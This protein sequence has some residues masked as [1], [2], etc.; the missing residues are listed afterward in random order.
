M[1]NTLEM[2]PLIVVRVP[3][4]HLD[5]GFDRFWNNNDPVATHMFNALSFLFP[6]GERYFINAAKAVRNSI[7]FD[8]AKLEE[9]IKK[10]IAQESVHTAQHQIYNQILEFQGYKNI[11]NTHLDWMEH[12]LN[13]HFSPLF[14]L[15]IVVAFEHYTAILGDWILNSPQPLE[16]ANKKMALIWGWHAIEEVEHK[17]VCFDLYEKAGGGYFMRIWAFLIVSVNFWILHMRNYQYALR[18]DGYLSFGNILKTIWKT[19]QFLFGKGGVG[20][21]LLRHSVVFWNPKFK[22]W[23]QNNNQQRQQW[24]K[25]NEVALTGNDM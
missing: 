13:R 8:D 25:K 23:H 4:L 17:S 24:L 21:H 18:Y 16:N 10:F 12:F 14:N 6:Q 5:V 1:S 22:P 2:R 9:E 15:A 3:K 20:R 19:A 7:E 11:S